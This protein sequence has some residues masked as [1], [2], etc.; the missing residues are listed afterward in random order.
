MKGFLV[1]IKFL[2]AG[3]VSWGH[4]RWSRELEWESVRAEEYDFDFLTYPHIEWSYSDFSEMPKSCFTSSITKVLSSE[5]RLS[6]VPSTL[7]RNSW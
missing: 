7:S 6:M 4:W 3:S 2:I 1:L 5:P